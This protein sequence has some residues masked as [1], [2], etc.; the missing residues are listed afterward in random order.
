MAKVRALSFVKNV[1]H[2][3]VRCLLIRPLMCLSLQGKYAS[4]LHVLLRSLHLYF[5][6]SLAPFRIHLYYAG[7]PGRLGE[8]PVTRRR[9]GPPVIEDCS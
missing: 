1:Q 5:I 2:V 6:R 7:D 3:V 9:P 8:E 4:A